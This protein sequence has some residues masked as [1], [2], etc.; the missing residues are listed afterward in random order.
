MYMYVHCIMCIS[1]VAPSVSLPAT[2]NVT[3]GAT[4][5]LDCQAFGVPMPTV[6]WYK[7]DILLVDSEDDRLTINEDSLIITD[8]YTTDS[9]VYS[10]TAVNIVNSATASS[11]VDVR[12]T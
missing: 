3:Q 9:G 12:S 6:V 2:L 7:N 1:V 5:F 4:I 11:L 10:C 8:A